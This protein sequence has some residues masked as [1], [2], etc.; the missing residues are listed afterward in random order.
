MPRGRLTLEFPLYMDRSARRFLEEL[1]R[2]PAPSG[3][4]GAAQD[5]WRSYVSKF[6]GK[7]ER[8]V[9]GNQY[10]TIEGRS[11]RG[12][13]LVG[14]IDEIGLIVQYIDDDGFIFVRAVGGVD[15][16]ILPSHRVRIAGRSGHVPGVIGK[17]AFHLRERD[18]EEKPPR[19]DDLYIDIGATK[20]A[21]AAARVEIGDPVV[22]GGDFE[23]L[24]GEFATA[25]NF[26]NRMGCF[27]VA[28]TLRRLSAGRKK[29]GYS[30]H[31]VSSVQEETG[32]WGAGNI[33]SHLRPAAAVAIDVT[34]DTHHPSVKRQR[35]GDIRCG[36]GPVLTR[37]VRSSKPLFEQIRSVAK[38]AKIPFQVETDQGHTHTD[39][40][41]ISTRDAGTPVAVLSVP[42]R[43]MHTSCEVI[44]LGDLEKAVDL[45]VALCLRL[46]PEQS[47]LPA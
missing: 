9:H 24:G 40:D 37:G 11:Q 41:P 22:F 3:Y 12:L 45:L 14:H 29:P 31:G 35:H 36:A 18:G 28:E 23:P 10:T 21:E 17:R 27:A 6:A 46:N 13:I 25:R 26:D 44:H 42:C 7:V 30:I 47:L 33:A 38:K 19:I 32:L 5:L 8:D 2:I 20:K 43:Y 39:A 15:V 1:L 16:S 34:H 4:E